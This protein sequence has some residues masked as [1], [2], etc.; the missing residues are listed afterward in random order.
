[1]AVRLSAKDRKAQIVGEVLKLADEIGPDRLSTTDVARAVGLS[2]PAI[3][4]HFPTKGSLW[5]AVAEDIAQHLTAAWDKADTVAPDARLKALIG[6]QLSAIAQTPALPSILFSRELQVDNPPLR[7]V[8]RRL[9]GVFQMHLVNAIT[10]QQS[11]GRL[12][13]DVS[14]TDIAILLTSLVQG[15]AIRWTLGARS[16]SV[17]EEGLRHFDVQMSLLQHQES[18]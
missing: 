8:F 10:D 12:R 7:D 3:F 6:A 16:F 2:Q 15:V 9:L 18:R 5:L 17:V 14:A 1:M 11:R 13:R 4:R